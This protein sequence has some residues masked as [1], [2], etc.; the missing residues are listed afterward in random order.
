MTEESDQPRIR[1][2]RAVADCPVWPG[3][4]RSSTGAHTTLMPSGKRSRAINR[5]CTAPLP[6]GVAIA[7][8]QLADP[9]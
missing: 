9:A 1:G 4:A 8:G 7:F 2:K 6:A 5:A 3:S